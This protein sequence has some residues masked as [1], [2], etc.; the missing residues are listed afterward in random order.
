MLFRQQIVHLPP[1]PLIRNCLPSYIVL[2]TLNTPFSLVILPLSK[3]RGFSLHIEHLLAPKAKISSTTCRVHHSEDSNKHLPTK[4]NH[5]LNQN[6][7][8][9]M[10]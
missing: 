1:I 5:S 7:Y 10:V 4:T 3:I 6:I 2:L 8:M 9:V